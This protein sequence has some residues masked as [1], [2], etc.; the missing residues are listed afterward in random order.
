MRGRRR[1]R[2]MQAPTVALDLQEH[3]N[4]PRRRFDSCMNTS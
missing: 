2:A 4:T 1:Y 3:N